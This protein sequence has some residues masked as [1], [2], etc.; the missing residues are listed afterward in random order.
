MS[1]IDL[2]VPGALT[3][4]SVAAL[5]A[6]KDDSAHRQLRVTSDGIAYLSDEVGNLNVTGLAFFI[7]TWNEGNDYVGQLASQDANWVQRVY[8]CLS[9]N[10]PTPSATY[11]DVY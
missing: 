6:S 3:L 8:N 2:K 9:S 1:Q 7:E 11:I 5:I 10:W 4:Q